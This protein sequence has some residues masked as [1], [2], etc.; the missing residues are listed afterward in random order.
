M[1]YSSSCSPFAVIFH[2]HY[3]YTLLKI[4]SLFILH[5]GIFQI[6]RICFLEF[7]GSGRDF[8]RHV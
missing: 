2:F 8:L 1:L 7:Q 3:E 4:M 6:D 5:H